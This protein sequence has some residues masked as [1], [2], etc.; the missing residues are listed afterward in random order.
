MGLENHR[1]G[2]AHLLALGAVG[3][4]GATNV[5]RP[6]RVGRAVVGGEQ[7]VWRE[8]HREEKYGGGENR[9]LQLNCRQV[10]EAFL[11]SVRGPKSYHRLP[12]TN[13]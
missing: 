3:G 5:H 8:I 11:L 9:C 6:L 1:R 7:V 13:P 10:V 4:D 2:V 12:S